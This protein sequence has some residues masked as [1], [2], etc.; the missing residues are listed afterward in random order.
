MSGSVGS[1]LEGRVSTSVTLLDAS[2]H[3]HLCL[4]VPLTRTAYSSPAMSVALEEPAQP[5]HL[6]QDTSDSLSAADVDPAL[7]QDNDALS[8]KEQSKEDLVLPVEPTTTTDDDAQLEI[9]PQGVL[10]LDAPLTKDNDVVLDKVAVEDAPVVEVRAV[11]ITARVARM[12]TL[13]TVTDNQ[14]KDSADVDGVVDESVE[15]AVPVESNGVA[16][17]ACRCVCASG[18]VC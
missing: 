9:K 18:I 3:C 17:G 4:S 16:I 15:A 12:F 5:A 11:I 14:I 13:F 6:L 8:K 10:E 7:A 2:S 1:P